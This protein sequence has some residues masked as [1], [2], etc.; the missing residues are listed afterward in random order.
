MTDEAV[1]AQERS[2]LVD[3]FKRAYQ[4]IVGVSITVACS[5]LFPGKFIS[6]PLDTSFWLFGRLL[7]DGCPDLSRRR[8]LARHQI[9]ASPTGGI[10]GTRRLRVGHLHVAHYGDLFRQNSSVGAHSARR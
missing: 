6:F 8:S 3:H 7:R 1:A 2:R 4:I 10:L 9:P 5:N